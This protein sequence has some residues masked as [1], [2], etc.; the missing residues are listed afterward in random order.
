MATD[1]IFPASA[2]VTLF[3]E[4]AGSQL[5]ALVKQ[6]NEFALNAVNAWSKA[7]AALPVPEVAE[8]PGVP[9]LPDYSALTSYSFDLAI[10]LLNTQR[11]F[12][13]QVGAA[14]AP[15]KAA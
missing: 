7:V 15:A 6:S 10:D 5:L 9:A 12:A 14:L 1:T 4:Q 2:D 11:E 8:I 13:L 3:A